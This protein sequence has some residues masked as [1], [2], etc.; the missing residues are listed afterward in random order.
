MSVRCRPRFKQGRRH[1]HRTA[2]AH[3]MSTPVGGTCNSAGLR[4]RHWA[5]IDFGL[6]ILGVLVPHVEAASDPRF[7]R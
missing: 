3:L 7:L 2:L 5:Y 1:P 6:S 4:F